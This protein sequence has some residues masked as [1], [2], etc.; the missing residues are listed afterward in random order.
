LTCGRRIVGPPEWCQA[1]SRSHGILKSRIPTLGSRIRS[2][3]PSICDYM[4]DLYSKYI[5]CTLVIMNSVYTVVLK[6]CSDTLNFSF[7]NKCCILNLWTFLVLDFGM[8]AHRDV[9]CLR[10]NNTRKMSWLHLNVYVA[11]YVK[12]RSCVCN[13]VYKF[14]YM[15]QKLLIAEQKCSKAR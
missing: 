7:D 2:G 6:L 4:A 10:S 15:T 11:S 12:E 3:F 14:V 9:A 8:H 1:G 5:D 13:H